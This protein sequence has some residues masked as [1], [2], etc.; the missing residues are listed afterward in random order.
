MFISRL[1]WRVTLAL[2]VAAAAAVTLVVP[3][4]ASTGARQVSPEMAGYSATNAQFKRMEAQVFLRNPAQYRGVV[5]SYRHSIQF[6]SSGVVVTVGV[7]ASTSGTSYTPYATIYNRSTHQVIS[8]NPNA[9][10]FRPFG[11][12]KELSLLIRYWPASGNLYMAGDVGGEPSFTSTYTLTAQLSFTQARVGT[13]FGSSPWDGSYSYTPP[14]ASVKVARY[15]AIL[16]SYSSFQEPLGS[17]QWVHHK[18]LANTGQQLVAVPHDLYNGGAS[19][20]TWF[21]PRSAESSNQ[22]T[23]P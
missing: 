10:G 21:E 1:R 18:V 4:G 15:A 19:F 23:A 17:R 2:G 22:P 7:R 9:T 6:W 3:A 13:E 12:G 11:F 8:S 16:V 14:A 20:Q 5:A